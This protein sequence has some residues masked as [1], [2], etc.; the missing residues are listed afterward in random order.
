MNMKHWKRGNWR[1]GIGATMAFFALGLAISIVADPGVAWGVVKSTPDVVVYNG[2][3]PAWPWID[4]TPSGKLLCVWREDTR[5][6]YSPDGHMM[7]STSVN[8]GNT[9]S[10]A[11]TFNDTANIDERSAAILPLSD[12]EWVVSYFTTNSSGVSHAMTTRTTNSGGTWSSPVS[13]NGALANSASWAAPIKLSNGDL[14]LP[15]YNAVSGSVQSMAAISHDN[16]A[17]WA[18]SY[19]IPNTSSF[20]GNE[21]SVV[22]RA[23]HSLVGILRNGGTVGGTL[24]GSLY[25]TTSADMGQTWSTPAMTN[26]VDTSSPHSPAQVFLRKEQLW[27]S[28]DCPRWVSVAMATTDD[29]NLTAWNVGSQMIAYQYNSAGTAAYDAG[30]ACSVAL[31]GDQRL[32]VDYNCSA[33]G[34]GSHKIVGYFVTL[35]EPSTLASAAVGLAVMAL[36][37]WRK[38]K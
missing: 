24:S 3:Y 21:W 25:V 22:E 14:L 13:V 8:Q 34:S 5:H 17:S 10:T 15:Y 12:T 28:Y 23:N 2:T 37:I 32:I 1:G 16:G 26:L 4:K 38:R 18:S 33:P 31:S 9:W 36:Y 27:V 6:T 11:V 19:S 30:Y 35:P 20:I 7:L 29:P